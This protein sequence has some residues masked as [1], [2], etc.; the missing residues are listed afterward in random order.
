MV[1]K[2]CI[3]KW[4]PAVSPMIFAAIPRRSKEILDSSVTEILRSHGAGGFSLINGL[5]Y[6][7]RCRFSLITDIQPRFFNELELFSTFIENM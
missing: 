6:F 2:L 4:T 5:E 3:M 7:L 1:Y